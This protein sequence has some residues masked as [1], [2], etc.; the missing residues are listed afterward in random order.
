MTDFNAEQLEQL[1]KSF[2]LISGIR[3]VLY[4]SEFKEIMSFPKND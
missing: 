3:F 4:N 1:M 2:Y